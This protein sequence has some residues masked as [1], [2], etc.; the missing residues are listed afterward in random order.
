MKTEALN[1]GREFYVSSGEWECSQLR[2][3]QD[4]QDVIQLRREERATGV[5]RAI[6]AATECYWLVALRD[7]EVAHVECWHDA[8]T[9]PRSMVTWTPNAVLA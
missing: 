7:G 8:A 9:L 2:I 4:I 3:S 1:D 6:D 5:V